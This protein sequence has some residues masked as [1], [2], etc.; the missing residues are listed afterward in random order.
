MRQFIDGKQHNTGYVTILEA[1]SIG[2]YNIHYCSI[3]EVFRVD[4]LVHT[5]NFATIST[6]YGKPVDTKLNERFRVSY[7]NEELKFNNQ[8]VNL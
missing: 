1:L 5:P 4:N 7:R 6:L 2:S 8:P 3:D